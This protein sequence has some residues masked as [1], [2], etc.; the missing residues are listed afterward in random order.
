MNKNVKN[1]NNNNNER[2]KIWIMKVLNL[3]PR[4]PNSRFNFIHFQLF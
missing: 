3:N 1:N 4:A 2:M